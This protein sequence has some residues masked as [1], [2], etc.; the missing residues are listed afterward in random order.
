M[1]KI[2]ISPERCTKGSFAFNRRF[3]CI[4]PI[5][6]IWL[7]GLFPLQCFLKSDSKIILM[8]SP[9][10]YYFAMTDR[11]GDV[12]YDIHVSTSYIFISIWQESHFCGTRPWYSKA[13]ANHEQIIIFPFVLRKS[14]L[15]L[16]LPSV[17]SHI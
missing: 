16:Q 12:G 10:S 2:G 3:L 1:Q 15:L 11:V 5:K 7:F 4:N 9:N 17:V 8:S 13:H 14:R 6:I